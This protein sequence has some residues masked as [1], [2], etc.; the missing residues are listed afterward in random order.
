MEYEGIKNKN[1][2]VLVICNIIFKRQK[3]YLLTENQSADISYSEFRQLVG[4][5]FL[6]P[7]KLCLDPMISHLYFRWIN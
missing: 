5:G 3:I 4:P 1:F 6:I 7:S 2:K